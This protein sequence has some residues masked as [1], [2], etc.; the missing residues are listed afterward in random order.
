MKK[1]K[2]DTSA[3]AG[4]FTWVVLLMTYLVVMLIWT[5]LWPATQ[6]MIDVGI[7]TNNALN[8]D[9]KD[10]MINV[11]VMIIEYFP[12]WLLFGL[13]IMGLAKSQKQEEY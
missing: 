13:T 8:A 3:S 5:A 7:E 9:D 2:S 11:M 6:A 1:F 4:A 12:I 10:P